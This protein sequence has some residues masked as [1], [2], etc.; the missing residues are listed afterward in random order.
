MDAAIEMFSRF[1]NLHNVKYM[2]VYVKYVNYI[3]DGDSKTFKG[4]IDAKS[5]K[6]VITCKKQC[7]D[8]VQKSMG[9]CFRNLKKNMKSLGGEGKL[10]SKLIDDF[11][12]YYELA[13]RRNSNSNKKMERNDI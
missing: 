7:I 9:T 3:G 6:V 4:I 12:V 11:T 8:H 10:T 1:E 13:I 5:Y 2:T